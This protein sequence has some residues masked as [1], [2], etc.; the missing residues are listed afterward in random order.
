M[1]AEKAAT[2]RLLPSLAEIDRTAWDALANPGWRVGPRGEI[3]PEAPLNQSLNSDF[4]FNENNNLNETAESDSRPVESLSEQPDSHPQSVESVS[5]PTARAPYNPFVSHDFLWSLEE[6]G[7]AVPETGWASC[8]LLLE[9]P[10]GEA[11]GIVPAYLKGHSQG[12]YVFDHGWADAFERA[13]GRYYPK[14]QISVPFTPATAPKLLVGAGPDAAARRQA[15]TAGILAATRQ[16]QASSAHLT[17]LPKDEADLLTEEDFLHRTDQQFH[18]FNDGYDSFD[19]FLASLASRKRKTIRRERRDAAQSDLEITWVTGNDITEAHWDAFY[20][21]YMDTGARKWGR[22][23]LNRLFF[24]LVGERMADRI[25]LVFAWRNGEAIAGALNFIG[26]NTLYGRHWGTVDPQ[27]F[28]HFE[29]CYYQAIDYAIEHGLARV[30]AGAQGPHKLARGYR[31][32]TTHSAHWIAHPGLREAVAHFLDHERSAVE[33]EN[34][35]LETMTPF[36]KA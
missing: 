14:L 35:L 15:L 30:E 1:S 17:F 34:A 7:C 33:E 2:I 32:V 9:G 25:L 20:S 22:P 26:S 4:E 36:K 11:A 31:P 29:A 24:S 21:F 23:Y 28:L 8:H 5:Q 6:A 19:D 13:G 16:L 10:D 3:A 12:E 27:P 18:W